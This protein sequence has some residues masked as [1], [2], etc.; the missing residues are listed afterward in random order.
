MHGGRQQLYEFDTR[1]RINAQNIYQNIYQNKIQTESKSLLNNNQIFNIKDQSAN[2]LIEYF[3]GMILSYISLNEEHGIRNDKL[4]NFIL[5]HNKN[6]KFKGGDE[7][8]NEN[9]KYIKEH[10][11]YKEYKKDEDIKDEDILQFSKKDW[12]HI[13]IEINIDYGSVYDIHINHNNGNNVIDLIIDLQHNTI[14]DN[15]Q[16]SYNNALCDSTKNITYILTHIIKI[17]LKY[18]YKNTCK[19][20]TLYIYD[21]N[22]KVIEEYKNDGNNE[23]S[24]KG[25]VSLLI[26]ILMLRNNTDEDTYKKYNTTFL[27]YKIYEKI[28]LCNDRDK[29]I[30]SNSFNIF[31][32]SNQN[33]LT[34]MKNDNHLI[35]Y[36][37][38]CALNTIMCVKNEDLREL[39]VDKISFSQNKFVKKEKK[40]SEY[41]FNKINNILDELP[42]VE[43]FKKY[44]NTIKKDIK[45]YNEFVNFINKEYPDFKNAVID[46]NYLDLDK[47]YQDKFGIM[48]EKC[49]KF[50][51]I[52]I[53]N[54]LDY[55]SKEIEETST[56]LEKE[57]KKIEEIYG[58]EIYEG[59]MERLRNLEKGIFKERKKPADD[60]WDDFD[61]DED[62]HTK[63][64]RKFMEV[65][66]VIIKYKDSLNI[67]Y[68]N[69]L[70]SLL[71]IKHK[72]NYLFDNNI[73]KI[74][75]YSKNKIDIIKCFRNVCYNENEYGLFFPM[76]QE[77]D[78]EEDKEEG[79]KYLFKYIAIGGMN[80]AVVL[81][82]N[83]NTNNNK[84]LYIYDINTLSLYIINKYDKSQGRNSILA[85]EDKYWVNNTADEYHIDNKSPRWI[86]KKY[87]S[88]V[89]IN[90]KN[91]DIFIIIN[92]IAF[93]NNLIKS[94]NKISIF[95]EKGNFD[96]EKLNVL[97][98]DECI[99]DNF[100][101]VYYNY[102][103]LIF[104][105]LLDYCNSSKNEYMQSSNNDF[106]YAVRFINGYIN[107]NIINYDNDIKNTLYKFIDCLVQC[108]YNLQLNK[109][110]RINIDEEY[111]TIL[112]NMTNTYSLATGK[113]GKYLNFIDDID[114]HNE[115]IELIVDIMKKLRYWSR[116]FK[117]VHGGN[118]VNANCYN[119][120][121][122]KILIVLLIIVIIIII[123]LIVLYIIN[124][125]KNNN[126]K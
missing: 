9:N 101:S 51:N 42:T 102:K 119:S 17:L 80:H 38:D 20:I 1:D 36:R 104:K 6:I 106:L 18:I 25:I 13:N 4:K 69:L 15:I 117:I 90:Y 122:K 62:D 70:I 11:T 35:G 34:Y 77:G 31:Q 28:S 33:L 55:N 19:Y 121:I 79:D 85:S 118:D 53:N 100:N 78:K 91:N 63:S 12:K 8:K 47:R 37:G 108:N 120:I 116:D 97:K 96:F 68:I 99:E 95:N 65:I 105:Q 54:L 58:N 82:I 107:E 39:F 3:E 14:I 52:I 84:V 112:K 114:K 5:S 103:K 87:Y 2:Y 27:I 44:I 89:P 26:M 22:K 29:E 56:K 7:D 23:L 109:G 40:E 73:M 115:F 43:G 92:N 98:Y 126:L 111:K 21:K 81:I 50:I 71:L 93:D 124:K 110:N 30:Y 83:I 49:K 24:F 94:L 48:R 10:K 67:F 125:Y 113:I 57:T 46:K 76:Y 45:K 88:D 66:E 75:K 16:K 123:V 41:Y 74:L 72:I 64:L 86:I 32:I 59:Q 60:E 61:E